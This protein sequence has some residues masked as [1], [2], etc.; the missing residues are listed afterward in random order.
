MTWEPEFEELMPHTIIV[1]R[2]TGRNDYGEVTWGTASTYQGRW[3]KQP[4]EILSATGE[5]TV[6]DGHVY[7]SGEVPPNISTL[8]QI[9]LPDGTTPNI[10]R[11][12]T[13]PDEDGEHHEVVYF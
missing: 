4:R 6:S 13:Y 2:S 11:V 10:L 3:V 1:R 8:D 12:D 5:Q 7:I 9:T